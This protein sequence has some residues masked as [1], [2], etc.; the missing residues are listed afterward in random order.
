MNNDVTKG[1]EQDAQ[2]IEERTPEMGSDELNAKWTAERLAE[3]MTRRGLTQAYVAKKLGVSTS[4]VSQYLRKKYKGNLAELTNKVHNWLESEE[5]REKRHRKKIF[6]ETT[7]AKK[8]KALITHVEAFSEGEGKIGLVIGDGGHGK[9]WCLQAFADTNR[10]SVYVELDDAMTST[11]MF[12][13]IAAALHI[14][15]AGSLSIITRRIIT[16]IYN[17]QMIV[18]LDE[19]SGL[20]V[21][22]LNQ[23]RQIIAVKSRCPLILAGN[24]DLLKTIAQPTTRKGYES[25]DQFTS[26]L[27][28]VLNLDDM[29]AGK[30]GGVYCAED[31]KKLYTYGGIKLSTDAVATLRKIAKSSRTGR[32]RTCSLI[33][34][35]LHVARAVDD[36][37]TGELII[38]AV[39]EL[40]LPQANKISLAVPDVKESQQKAKAG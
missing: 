13:E 10:N 34:E 21:T 30:N 28:Q 40:G 7:V 37:I 39:H 14:D 16:H 1:L 17:R 22:R 32:L 11:Q 38:A 4:I 33:I 12:A 3:C 36:L 15:S 27:M 20:S 26:R 31:I 8:I 19:A 24:A 2:V 9:S 6:V 18:I 5:R 29:A 35:A 25:L 23:L